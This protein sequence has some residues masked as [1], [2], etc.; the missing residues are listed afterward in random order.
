MEKVLSDWHAVPLSKFRDSFCVLFCPVLRFCPLQ[1]T[2]RPFFPRQLL[3]PP[4]FTASRHY[5][6]ELG[7]RSLIRAAR[8]AG[9]K[10]REQTRAYTSLFYSRVG[11]AAEGVERVLLWWAVGQA[12]AGLGKVS[13]GAEK[14]LELLADSQEVGELECA[15]WD[16]RPFPETSHT[17]EA[18]E[19]T[20]S[21]H[22]GID[23][24]DLF[25]MGAA[26]ESWP[27]PIREYWGCMPSP[28]PAMNSCP[29]VLVDIFF[30]QDDTVHIIL[31]VTESPWASTMAVEGLVRLEKV[32]EM[33]VG[34][35]REIC[36]W[37]SPGL[38]LTDSAKTDS[39]IYFDA[40][41]VDLW[42]CS[43]SE[44]SIDEPCTTG[45]DSL[46]RPSLSMTTLMGER[47]ESATRKVGQSTPSNQ[48]SNDPARVLRFRRL[49]D[50]D[51][52]KESVYFEKNAFDFDPIWTERDGSC[53]DFFRRLQRHSFQ[54]S[55]RSRRKRYGFRAILKQYR[56]WKSTSIEISIIR[57][58]LKKKL[59]CCGRGEWSDYE[60]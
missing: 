55:C 43:E 23:V 44:G 13:M 4:C 39:A 29:E 30:T 54:P 42:E 6:N 20:E 9:A 34:R 22:D 33:R 19:N 3:P 52:A 49:R 41:E 58:R 24:V 60:D 53:S 38:L 21:Q 28:Q 16:P 50:L 31:T 14:Q 48:S 26:H 35:K 1:V 17:C 8:S 59:L 7:M 10:G 32:R 51:S 56:K 40:V 46:V 45:C 27:E 15:E 36:A 25:P 57:G 37:R 11:S 47:K 12:I 18:G 5:D 2:S